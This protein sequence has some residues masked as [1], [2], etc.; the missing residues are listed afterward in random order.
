MSEPFTKGHCGN[1]VGSNMAPAPKRA[2]GHRVDEETG[3]MQWMLVAWFKPNALVQ[4][5]ENIGWME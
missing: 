1:Y 3:P 5:G 4:I 2:L